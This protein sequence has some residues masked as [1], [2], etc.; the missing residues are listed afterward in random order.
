MRLSAGMQK[1]VKSQLGI[2]D[3]SGTLERCAAFYE[4]MI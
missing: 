1:A 4:V 3:E 2:Y